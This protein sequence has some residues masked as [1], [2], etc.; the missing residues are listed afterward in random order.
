MSL[1]ISVSSSSARR[2]SSI[3]LFPAT[4]W[5]IFPTR[6]WWVLNKPSLSRLKNP[7][8]SSAIFPPKNRKG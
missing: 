2:S 6:V 4:I 3:F 1:V 7:F 8:F 5:S